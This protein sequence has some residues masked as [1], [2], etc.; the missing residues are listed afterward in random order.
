MSAN[1]DVDFVML[2]VGY[3]GYTEGGL[4]LDSSFEDNKAAVIK[5]KVPTGLY[6]FTQAIT[7]DEG[8]EEAKF[9]LKQIGKMKVT[10]P[11]VIDSELIGD[12]EARGDNASVD[13]RTDGVVGFCETIK[14]A[15]YTPMIYAKALGKH[16]PAEICLP[17]ALTWTDLATTSCGL[18]TMQMSQTF[19]INIRDGSTQNPEVLTACT[20]MLI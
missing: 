4:M 14:A 17:S 18:P 5:H 16:M 9:V 20:V 8:V 12:N 1:K 19:H 10:Y 7:Y 11:I 13:E 15:G 2:R 3:R 6:F